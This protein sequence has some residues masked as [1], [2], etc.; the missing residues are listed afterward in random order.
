MAS[1]LIQYFIAT[2]VVHWRQLVRCKEGNEFIKMS[3]QTNERKKKSSRKFINKL[4]SWF[5][6]EIA[7]IGIDAY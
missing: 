3:E 2:A 4:A 6:T 5:P 1:V 7:A